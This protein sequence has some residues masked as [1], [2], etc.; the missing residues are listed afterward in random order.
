MGLS[1][2]LY[3]KKTDWAVLQ[4]G[5][6]DPLGPDQRL[7]TSVIQHT[8]LGVFLSKC[9]FERRGA[10]ANISGACVLSMYASSAR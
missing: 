7:G 4:L 1:S 10:L 3:M 9:I 6:D 8:F 5:G 2:T